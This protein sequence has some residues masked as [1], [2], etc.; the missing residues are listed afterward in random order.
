MNNSIKILK[1]L[2]KIKP[3]KVP[4]NITVMNPYQN[5][6]NWS[7]VKKYY[8]KYYNDEKSRTLIFGINPGRLGGGLTGIPFTDPVNL[9]KYCLINNSIDKKRE[10]SSKFIYELIDEYGGVEKF[11]KKFFITSVC[12]FGFT[13]NGKNFNYYDNQLILK[14]WRNQIAKWIDYQV[15]KIKNNKVCFVIG[16]GKNQNFFEMINKEFKFFNEIIS[17]PHPRWILQYRSKQKNRF[18]KEYITK[19]NKAT[20]DN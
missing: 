20:N 14:H 17:L 7:L 19:L 9:E 1:F 10:I 12:P 3:L 15:R 6:Y 13:K 11:Y 8:N 16:K 4:K 5:H 18:I 2:K